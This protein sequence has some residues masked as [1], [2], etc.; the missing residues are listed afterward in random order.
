M[1]LQKL[2]HLLPPSLFSLVVFSRVQG[3]CIAW[4]QTN[5]NVDRA[6]SANLCEYTRLDPPRLLG[7][8]VHRRARHFSMH[9]DETSNKGL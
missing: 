5:L 1:P 8:E 3:H 6:K 4:P 2:W 7:L 9:L